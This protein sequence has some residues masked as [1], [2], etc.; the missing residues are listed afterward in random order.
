MILRIAENTRNFGDGRHPFPGAFAKRWP[1]CCIRYTAGVLNKCVTMKVCKFKACA[2]LHCSRGGKQIV[3][4]AW[5]VCRQHIGD[6][7]VAAARSTETQE[8]DGGVP[9]A[10]TRTG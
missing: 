6:V 7:D 3:L 1:T 9:T 4:N 8:E 10:R 5:G 2:E